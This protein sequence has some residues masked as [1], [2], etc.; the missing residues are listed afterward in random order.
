[1][2]EAIGSSASP[3]RVVSRGELFLGFLKCGLLGFGGVAPWARHIIVEERRWLSERDYAALLGVGQ[4]LPGANTVN[5]AVM[6]GDR[7]QGPVGA[8]LC[9][10]GLMALPLVILIAIA[11]VYSSFASDPYVEAAMGGAAAGAAGLI[12]GTAMKMIRA[13]RLKPVALVFGTAA[14]GAI[15]ILG[16]SFMPVLAVLIPASIAAAALEMRR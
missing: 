15:G 6:I 3:Q 12:I 7:F 8:I 11:T 5:A 14:F 16:W 4:A 10:V 2:N 1:M 9:V 13:L